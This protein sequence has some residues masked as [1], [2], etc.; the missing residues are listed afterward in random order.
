MDEATDDRTGANEDGAT[1]NELNDEKNQK[2]DSAP[3]ES[4]CLSEEEKELEELRLELIQVQEEILTLK[5]VLNT[6]M[7]VAG[8][9]RRKLGIT[10]ITE[11]RQS[12]QNIKESGTYQKTNAAFRSFGAFASRKMGNL[13]NSSV[14]KSVEEKVGGAYGTVKFQYE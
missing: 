10:P 8:D 14:F 12:I 6:K 13:R 11:L 1:G 4:K 5:A 7:K 2:P 9:L 3:S